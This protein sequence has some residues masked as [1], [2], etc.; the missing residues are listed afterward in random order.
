MAGS[1]RSSNPVGSWLI[2]HLRVLISSLGHLTRH[3]VPTAMTSSVIAIALALPTGLYIALGNVGQLGADWDDSAQISLFMHGNASQEQAEDL[4]ARL[5]LHRQVRTITV[6]SKSQGLEQ[7]NEQSGFGDALKHLDENPLPIV[8]S[9]LPIVD[10]ARP[11]DIRQLVEELQQEKFVDIARL[12]LEWVQRLYAII[13]IAQRGTWM[14]GALLALAV[15]LIVGNTIRLDIQNRR[16]EILVAKLIGASNAFIR[17]PFLYTGIWYGL[18]GGT[19]AWCL[20]SLSLLLLDPP[21]SKLSGLYQ[22]DFELS[23]LT[24]VNALVLLLVSCGL[25]LAGSW[26]AV[27]RHLDEIEPT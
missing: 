21:V 7:F 20:T 26:L 10:P 13:E 11:A 5:R 1:R 14:V 23:G 4:A 9:V 25:G 12:D 24:L 19:L 22:S 16:E 15:L 17:R 18:L 8:L 3:L 2:N 6:I 27:G